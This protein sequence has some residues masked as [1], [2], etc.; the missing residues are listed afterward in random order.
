M[1]SHHIFF[2]ISYNRNQAIENY[3]NLRMKLTDTYVGAE[4]QSTCNIWFAKQMPGSARKR[5]LLARRNNFQSPG[6]R[7]SYLAR[8]RKTFTC[9][10]LQ[11][12]GLPKEKLVLNIR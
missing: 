2:F 10:N 6:K 12:L 1:T 8:R 11:N 3:E 7:L 9:G 5:N 4:T